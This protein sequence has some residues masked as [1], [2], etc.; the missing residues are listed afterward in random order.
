MKLYYVRVSSVLIYLITM[1]LPYSS[2]IY[3]LGLLSILLICKC[4]NVLANAGLYYSN[5]I[6]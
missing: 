4:E 2:V 3:I 1:Y 6:D 5:S